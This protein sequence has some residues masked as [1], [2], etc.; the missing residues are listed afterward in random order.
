MDAKNIIGELSKAEKIKH[1]LEKEGKKILVYHRD[2]DG[3]CSAALFL[4]FFEGFKRIP[5]EG[6]VIDTSFFK[7]VVDNQPKVLVFLD[8]PVDQEW[9]KILS[10]KEKIPD[11][12]IAIIDH[13][14]I[15]KNMNSD[16]ILHINP[17]FYGDSYIPASCV[18]YELLRNIGFDV[19][20]FNW[21]ALIGIIGDYGV[22]DCEWMFEEQKKIDDTPH[23]ELIKASEIIASSI[24]LKGIKGC[25]K[26]LTVLL[27]SQNYK[28]FA[29]SSELKRWNKIVQTEI[30]RLTKAFEKDKE[31]FEEKNVIFFEIKS[32]MNITSI[33]ATIVAEKYP[34]NIIIIRK[35]SGDKWKI[36]LRYQKGDIN[37]GNFAKKASEG[38][39]SGGG[40]VKS[41]GA[42]VNNWEKFKKRIL[43][44]L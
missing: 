22:K 16:D 38:I 1:W 30:K 27:K 42:L 44:M 34:N 41:A 36:S 19:K 20:P 8:I 32:K 28:D 17:M 18:V 25:E 3:V 43:E 26:A 21:I 9:K 15:E 4:K 12:K 2:V 13:H 33:I 11:I 5:R 23:C 24:T 6:P 40:H 37:M 14:L 35:K 39:G 10:L 7:E 29:K 31:F